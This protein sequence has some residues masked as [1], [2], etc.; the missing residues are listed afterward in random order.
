MP[1]TPRDNTLYQKVKKKVYRDIPKHSAYRSGILVQQYKAA[2]ARKYG[3]SKN[4]YLEKKKTSKTGL[5]RWFR[6]KWVNQRGEV[7][8]K[9][10]SDIYRPSKRI[11][12]KTPVTHG[13]LKVSEISRA[14]REKFRTGH[15]NRFRGANKK[16]K[17]RGLRK[18][19]RSV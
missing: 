4:P 2:F 17:R 11:T 13:E 18:K 10:K 7:G 15:V 19:N 9:H 14:R 12:N 8:Y 5:A 1:N 16:T 3:P 6:E